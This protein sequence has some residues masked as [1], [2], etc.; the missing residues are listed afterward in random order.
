MGASIVALASV[1]TPSL[2][3]SRAGPPP[4]ARQPSDPFAG[5]MSR[6]DLDHDGILTCEEWK[7]FAGQVF[8][9]ADRN[10]DGVLDGPEFS[11]LGRLEPILAKADMAYFDANQDGRLSLREF[12]DTPNPIFGRYDR[13]HDCQVTADE[14]KGAPSGGKQKLP[15]IGE[16]GRGGIQRPPPSN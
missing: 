11:M 3:Q 13:D 8:R 15:A 9:R 16:G 7:R 10:G 6:W 12:V 5:A 2:A 14:I 1:G 4:A